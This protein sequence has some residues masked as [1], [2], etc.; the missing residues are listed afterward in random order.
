MKIIIFFTLAILFCWK[1]ESL[2]LYGEKIPRGTSSL[3]RI[4]RAVQNI[5]SAIV[6]LDAQFIYFVDLIAPLHQEELDKL[7]KILNATLAQS[8]IN[9]EGFQALVIPRLGT[10]SPWSSKATDILRNCGIE[11]I[12][13]IEKGKIYFLRSKEELNL[14]A[15]APLLHDKMVES[16]LENIEQGKHVFTHSEPAPFS[17]VAKEKEILEETNKRLGLA[18]SPQ[19]IEYLLNSYE[20][21][22]RGISD[23]E[24]MTF[25]QVNSEHCRH[26]IFNA[27]WKIDHLPKL[28]SLFDMIKNTVRQNPSG[29]LSA[30]SDNAA[31]VE[32]AHTIC[33]LPNPTTGIY[34]EHE[35]DI[36]VIIKVETH[37]HP[38]SISPFPG[39]ATGVGGEIRDEGATGRGGRPKAG[40]AGYCVSNLR[41]P[42]GI[43]PLDLHI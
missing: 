17:L 43:Q 41:L 21:L 5:D 42:H 4:E 15:V 18:L 25:A 9:D 29:V 31:V 7:C 32:G 22:G 10:V 3:Q 33:F 37:N 30:F 2:V 1:T 11:N 34:E 40:L 14:A 38:T 39:A 23:V 20:E 28:Y 8:R 35:E 6:Q 24:L 27:H 16:F 13:R 12:R 19:E 36:S 26:K